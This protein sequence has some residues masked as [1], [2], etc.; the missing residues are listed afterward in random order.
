MSNQ[1]NSDFS[2]WY[3]ANFMEDFDYSECY[4]IYMDGD[5]MD[6]ILP[7]NNKGN[8]TKPYYI[9]RLYPYADDKPNEC[10]YEGM[11][12]QLFNLVELIYT[13]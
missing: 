6:S 1:A 12:N 9:E 7:V 8:L 5:D 2:N 11:E 10:L 13:D 4:I 3:F